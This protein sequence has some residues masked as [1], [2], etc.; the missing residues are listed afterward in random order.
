MGVQVADSEHTPKPSLWCHLHRAGGLFLPSLLEQHLLPPSYRLLSSHTA[1]P[2]PA[3]NHSFV[4]AE[5][6]AHKA[7][8]SDL[9]IGTFS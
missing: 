4:L 6:S 5:L 9:L 8:P 1:S 3:S 7:L 2:L